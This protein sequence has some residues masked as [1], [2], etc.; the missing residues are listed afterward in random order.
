[1]SHASQATLRPVRAADLDAVL[2]VQ[3]ACYPPAMQEPATVVAAR[4]EQAGDTSFVAVHQNGAILGYVFA[5]RSRLGA[6][7]PLDAHFEVDPQGDALYLHDLAVA[8]EATGLGLARRLAAQLLAQARDTRLDWCALVSVQDS[9][10]FWERLG[11]RVAGCDTH[12]A[13]AALATYPEPA[14]YMTRPAHP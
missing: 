8:P 13:R 4:I 5:Y 2:Q 3:A 14:L 11:Y 7:T 12:A 1:M 9:R 10:G 6:V